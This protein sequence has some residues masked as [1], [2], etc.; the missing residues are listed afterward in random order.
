MCTKTKGTHESERWTHG[1]QEED[2]STAAA[3]RIKQEGEKNTKLSL[4]T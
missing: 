4:K 2:N 1:T 3:N